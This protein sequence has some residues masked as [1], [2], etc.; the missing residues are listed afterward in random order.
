MYNE[1]NQHKKSDTVKWIISFLLIAVLLAG[2]IGAWAVLLNDHS[3]EQESERKISSSVTDGDGNAMLSGELYAM[4]TKMIF[5]SA[6]S[7]QGG[8]DDGVRLMATVFPET[9]SNKALDWEVEFIESESAWAS[10]KTVSDYV[11]VIPDSDGAQIV[12]VRCLKP[13][14]EQIRISA[15]SRANPYAKAECTLDYARRISD[16]AIYSEHLDSNILDFGENELVMDMNACNYADFANGL[17]TGEIW[18]G[19]CYNTYLGAFQLTPEEEADP[20][21]KWADEW[22]EQTYRFTDYTIKD[23]LI[24]GAMNGSEYNAQTTF[25]M[26][27]ADGFLDLVNEFHNMLFSSMGKPPITEYNKRYYIGNNPVAIALE[28]FDALDVN[29]LN[30]IS[31]EVYA[32]ILGKMIQWIQANPDTPIF[33]YTVAYTGKYSTYS[34]T[35][36]FRFNPDTL[37]MPVFSVSMDQNTIV[38]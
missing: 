11:Q 1:L 14:G 19:N 4:P 3:E 10:G 24:V 23:C 38:M 20:E 8:S 2:M 5:A 25:E 22:L 37:Q 7:E 15:I 29:A 12:S 32:D 9:A 27:V 34:K 36:T 18:A 21:V 33:T 16:I 35:C 26:E 30:I 17:E 28:M 13:F 6:A 31:E